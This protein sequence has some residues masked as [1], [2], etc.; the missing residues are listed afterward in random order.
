MSQNFNAHQGWTAGEVT[1][2]GITLHYEYKGEPSAPAVLLVAGLG[3]QL[4]MWP[5]AFCGDLVSKGFRV[6]RFDNRD[7]GH[8]QKTGKGVRFN[9][10]VDFVKAKFGLPIASN[11]TLHDMAEDAAGLIQA[12]KLDK[13]HVVGI[14]M[15]GM[16]SQLLAAK[17]PQLLGKLSL[18]MTSTNHPSLPGP[19][20]NVLNNMFLKAPRDKSVEAYC[21]H[22]V[23]V[24]KAIGSPD[25]PTPAD[26]L[27]ATAKASFE[28]SR[29]PAGVLRQTNAIMATGSIERWSKS[30]KVP[31]LVIHGKE[32]PLLRLACGKRV[33][34]LI[35]G[36]R[37]EVIP[38]MG[39]DL[40]APLLGTLAGLIKS[41]E[42]SINI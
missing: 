6:I 23:R 27:R 24:F 30:I 4:T 22:V 14:S 21:D 10:P 37:L 29:R 36:A 8:S 11:Y 26:E 15:G 28:R 32:D 25:Y 9:I 16:I 2:N 20:W 19:T 17:Y 3:C 5:E 39:H 18:L 13:P 7:I 42:Y 41:H 35:P 40:P 31:T 33:S 38:G 34:K 12:L 1:T